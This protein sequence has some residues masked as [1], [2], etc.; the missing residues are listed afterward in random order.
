M[1]L[2]CIALLTILFGVFQYF[3]YNEHIRSSAWFVN[4]G[5]IPKSYDLGG[6]T[7]MTTLDLDKVVSP[8]AAGV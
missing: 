2:G 7:L 6:S 5:S 8:S 3:V 4:V 1:L